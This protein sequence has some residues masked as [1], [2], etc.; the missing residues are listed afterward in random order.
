[1]SRV[2]KRLRSSL[3]LPMHRRGPPIDQ[4]LAMFGVADFDIA[5][6]ARRTIKVSAFGVRYTSKHVDLMC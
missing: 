4:L 2:V 6:C 3:I 5:P 1:M